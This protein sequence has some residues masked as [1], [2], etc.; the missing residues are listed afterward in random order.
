[1]RKNRGASNNVPLSSSTRI[2]ANS[3]KIGT[4]VK[5][6]LLFTAVCLGIWG[7]LHHPLYEDFR[8]SRLSL[9]QF[10]K[11]LKNHSDDPAFLYHLGRK[12]NQNERFVE[13]DPFL[14]KAVGI[15]PEN[16]EYRDEWTKSLLGS[17]LTTAA[18]GQLREFVARHDKLA[19]AH[20]LLGKFYAT[21]NSMKHAKEEMEK[22]LA[23]N[24]SIGEAWALLS[25]A[26]MNL[27][28]EQSALAAAKKA[29]ELRP[30]NADDH[31]LYAR[32]LAHSKQLQLA[33]LEIEQALRIAPNQWDALRDHADFVI[34]NGEA[35]DLPNALIE[36]KRSV[37]V[38]ENEPSN[39][40]TYGRALRKSGF[41]IEALSPLERAANLGRDDLL[42]A[43]ELS[44]TNRELGRNKE[45]DTWNE[46]YLKR[47]TYEQDRV[48]LW[49]ALRVQPQ[50]ANIHKKL[51]NLLAS[52]GDT[53]ACLRQFAAA[54]H[55]AVDAPPA[56][57]PAAN[58]LTESGFATRALP[59]AQRAVFIA[60][61]NPKAHEALGNALLGIGKLH[62][63]GLEYD[64]VVGWEPERRPILKKKLEDFV[65]VSAKHPS[66]AEQAYR[67]AKNMAQEQVGPRQMTPEVEALAKRAVA[68]EPSNPI[69]A[70]FLMEVQIAQKEKE[71]AILSARNLLR[72]VP[73]DT[74]GNALLGLLLAEK[75]KTDTDFKEASK[76]LKQAATDPL[77]K[78]TY[79][80]GL[81]VLA[82]RQ[83][84]GEAAVREL[85]LAV[86]Y[87]PKSDVGYYQLALAQKMIGDS[88]AS[89]KSL[90]IFTKR[91][92]AKKQL[93][94]ALGDIA[95]HPD[96][97]KLYERAAT[98]YEANDLKDQAQA[99]RQAKN[100]RMHKR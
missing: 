98:L 84:Q 15:S 56:L 54:F 94:N 87:D 92:E 53:E 100:I 7:V 41:A 28:N 3:G 16:P 80:Y 19:E 37:G 21:Q 1:M 12:L 43:L 46:E 23:L 88:T 72:I 60:E 62:Q 66:L 50:N 74:R 51:A 69:Y 40:F 82:L 67:E 58:S 96:E 33:K 14:R 32:L 36:A 71:E 63:A 65:S 75:A 90:S 27:N 26:E 83:N 57:I 9:P 22:T 76:Y 77:V 79:H 45:A 91:Q 73:R 13:A 95:Q 8:Y 99:I 30:G 78:A 18:Y 93:S 20:L 38:R 68:L 59:L 81:G 6:V 34:A 44:Q 10:Q 52:H 70:W 47:K 49:E 85:K 5:I 29:V 24:S 2:K 97:F 86:E 64:K 61:S 55:C 89:A 42:S 35:K 31:L 48:A 4:I 17:G 25:I 11:E 39:L